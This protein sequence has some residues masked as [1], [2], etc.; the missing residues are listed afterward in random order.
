MVVENRMLPPRFFPPQKNNIPATACGPH[1]ISAI[2]KTGYQIGMIYVNMLLSIFSPGSVGNP[3]PG[4]EV[5]IATE[6]PQKEGS[7]YTVLAQG[8]ATGTEVMVQSGQWRWVSL[9]PL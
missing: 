2:G 5:R 4:V 1:S 3:L 7:I 8:D 6:V 9:H